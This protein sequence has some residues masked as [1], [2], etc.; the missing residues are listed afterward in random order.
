MHRLVSRRV[1]VSKFTSSK[2]V[3]QIPQTK[4]PTYNI[5]L[6]RIWSIVLGLS[7]FYG[8]YL[9]VQEDIWRVRCRVFHWK[10]LNSV[11]YFTLIFWLGL[12]RR[13]ICPFNTRSAEERKSGWF[14][15]RY[16]LVINIR[17][18]VSVRR[19]LSNEVIKHDELQRPFHLGFKLSNTMARYLLV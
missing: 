8:V 4:F 3:S 5:L 18:S 11:L 16:D 17:R 19:N 7:H 10:L 12:I 15:T 1:R 13:E 2:N 14:Q 9:S 6:T